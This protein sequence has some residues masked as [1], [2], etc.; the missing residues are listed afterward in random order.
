MTNFDACAFYSC[1]EDEE[2]LTH[3][4]PGAALDEHLENY[5]GRPG[6]TNRQTMERI[7]GTVTV[8]GFKCDVVDPA[9]ISTLCR[10]LATRVAEDFGNDHGDPEGYSTAPDGFT[11][12]VVDKTASAIKAAIEPII[13]EHGNVWNYKRIASRTFTTDDVVAMLGEE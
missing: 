1:R 12:A 9:W 5:V 3:D 13:R 6:E 4:S 10:S 2:R 8:H 11:R 7:G